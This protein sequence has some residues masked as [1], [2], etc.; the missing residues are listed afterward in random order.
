MLPCFKCCIRI[1][2]GMSNVLLSCCGV[3]NINWEA[4]F[5]GD[6]SGTG[7]CKSLVQMKFSFR[8]LEL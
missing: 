7:S 3:W 6:P 4:I 8:R 2:F 1:S 5:P